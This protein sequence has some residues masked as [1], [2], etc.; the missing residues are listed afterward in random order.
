MAD[1]GFWGRSGSRKRAYRI[2]VSVWTFVIV[3]VYLFGVFEM[4]DW[5]GGNAAPLLV[6][7][8]TILLPLVWFLG[9][10]LSVFLFGPLDDQAVREN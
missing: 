2:T 8:L 1:S 9:F 7:L 4:R 6:P 5:A 3:G 10:L